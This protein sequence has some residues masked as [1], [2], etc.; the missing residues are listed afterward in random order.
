[1]SEDH[2]TVLMS[3]DHSTV[4]REELQED[5]TVQRFDHDESRILV[6]PAAMPHSC[7]ESG[8]AIG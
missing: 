3:E 7:L 1:M 8:Q 5:L 4:L 2:S 6:R